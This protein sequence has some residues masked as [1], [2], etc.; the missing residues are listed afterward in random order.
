MESFSEPAA[1]EPAAVEPAS[2]NP[3]FL[4][5]GSDTPR[6]ADLPLTTPGDFAEREDR[7]SLDT[8]T[9]V[10]TESA[11]AMLYYAPEASAEDTEDVFEAFAVD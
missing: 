1:V 8:A 9:E 6:P 5:L 3:L 2:S 10:T 4:L 7:P 11:Y